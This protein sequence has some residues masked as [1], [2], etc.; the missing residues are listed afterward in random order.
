MLKRFEIVPHLQTWD[1]RHNQVRFQSCGRKRD[2]IRVAL[3]LG[4]LQ[5]RMGDEAEIVLRGPGGAA[6]AT[7]R[8]LVSG[9]SSH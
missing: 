8:F 7:R 9:L 5:Q 3:A 6:L 4:H 1:V 2:A